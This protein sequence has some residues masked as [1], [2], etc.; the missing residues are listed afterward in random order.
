MCVHGPLSRP[1]QELVRVL[2][3][4]FG[5]HFGHGFALAD[6]GFSLFGAHMGRDVRHVIGRHLGHRRHVA[7]L[8]VMGAHAVLDRELKRNVG[9]MRRLIDTMQERRSLVRSVQANAMT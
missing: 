2:M 5:V 4:V 3:T 6:T 7:K 1:V 8:P 9:V